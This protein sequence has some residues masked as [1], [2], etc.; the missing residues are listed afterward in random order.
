MKSQVIKY[1]AGSWH[2]DPSND[3]IPEKVDLILVYADRLLLNNNDILQ[4][5]QQKYSKAKVVVCSTAG[6]IYQRTVIENAASAMVI[7]FDKTEVCVETG[8]ISK[9]EDSNE[10]GKAIA[11]KFKPE[12][13]KYLMVISDGGEINGDDLI[14]GIKSVMGK[15]VCISG[16]MA[17]DGPRFQKTL[18]GCYP[19]VKEGNLVLIGF[20]GDKLKV[21]TG[22]KGGWDEFGPQ[23]TVTKSTSNVLYEIDGINALELYK[24]YLGTY[25]DDLPGSA[26]LFPI[27]IKTADTDFYLVRTIL[28]IDEEKQCMVFAGNI[29]EGSA[30]RFMKSNPDRLVF[31]AA[32]AGGQI[33]QNMQDIPV[34]MAMIVSCVGRKIVLSERIEEEI[35]AV[36]EMFPANANVAGFFSYGEIAPYKKEKQT[37]LHNQ[38]ITVTA[39]AEI[40]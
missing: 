28:S 26:L 24:K 32:D 8:E 9:Y 6:E 35:E 34:E 13:L 23:R 7:S 30:V 4:P 2:H 37:S 15:D 31:A 10:L 20:Y 27:S 25:K 3:I 40:S 36:A 22:V 29:P 33:L 18:V 5:L 12:G 21:A 16:G 11:Q 1:E 39:F 17:G 19:D 14:L 38:T